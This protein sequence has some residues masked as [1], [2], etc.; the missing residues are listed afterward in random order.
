MYASERPPRTARGS[1]AFSR[2]RLLPALPA[3]ATKH[4]TDGGARLRVRI[5]RQ[6]SSPG[7]SLRRGPEELWK[8]AGRPECGK[9]ATPR[10]TGGRRAGLDRFRGVGDGAGL[11]FNVA[12]LLHE[13]SICS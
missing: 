4:V 8:R 7:C 3:R 1:R 5:P 13:A 2:P 10:D 6:P 12:W 11:C 9:V